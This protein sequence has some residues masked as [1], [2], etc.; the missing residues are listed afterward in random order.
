[1]IKNDVFRCLVSF[2]KAQSH[3]PMFDVVQWPSLS[4][5]N[6][7]L[8]KDSWNSGTIEVNF[9]FRAGHRTD[10]PN[11]GLYREFRDGWHLWYKQHLLIVNN[12]KPHPPIHVHVLLC[13]T[14]G[15][16]NTHK[17]RHMHK[18]T[19][20]VPNSCYSIHVIGWP[21][22]TIVTTVA[23]CCVNFAVAH[24]YH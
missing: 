24:E 21:I 10:A 2:A 11:P 16:T 14:G 5:E 15:H 4:L 19:A 9:H 8:T 17:H 3:F 13:C 22:V 7:Y 23:V 1:M 6:Q 12:G 20:V 18:Q